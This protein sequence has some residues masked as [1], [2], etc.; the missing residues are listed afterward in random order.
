[1]RNL[2]ISDQIIVTGLI[3]N[4]LPFLDDIDQAN[5]GKE[6]NMERF[7]MNNLLIPED[8]PV[9]GKNESCQLSLDY[10]LTQ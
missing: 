5:D 9:L 8:T 10:T 2:I 3:K 6:I 7:I 4:R 1:M